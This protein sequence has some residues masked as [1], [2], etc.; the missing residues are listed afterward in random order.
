MPQ[1]ANAAPGDI[2]FEDDFTLY[3]LSPQ[4]TLSAPGFGTGF[5]SILS[6]NSAFFS[7]A[8][9]GGPLTLTTNSSINTSGISGAE[10]SVWVRRAAFLAPEGNDDLV[11]EYLNDSG[12]WI[13][14]ETYAGGGAPGQ[15]FNDTFT[16]PADALHAG[17]QL[18]FD[19]VQA[20]LGDYWYIDDVIVTETGVAVVCDAYTDT[21]STT[22]YNNSDGVLDWSS[23]SWFE[24]NDDGSSTSGD[25]EING[26][27]LRLSGN[28]SAVNNTM[29]TRQ[30]NTG[31][32]TSAT[33]SFD[34]LMI[35]GVDTADSALLEISDDG[36]SSWTTL[37]TFVGYSNNSGGSREYDITSY[38]ASNMQ[39]RFAISPD[40][41]GQCCFDSGGE[42]WEI[43]NVSVAACITSSVDHYFISHSGSGV[44]CESVDVSII[45]HDSSHV[46]TDAGGNTIQVTATSA[47]L[48]WS[49]ANTGWT[50][51]SGTGG[52]TAPSTGVAEYTFGSGEAAVTLNFS[53]TSV[54]TI[55]FDV[56]DQGNPSLTDIDGD[57]T[58][59]ASLTF[60]DT[61]F[62]FYD[63]SD[64]DGNRDP[65]GLGGFEGIQSELVAGAASNQMI[66]R[67]VQ[68]NNETGACEARV[69]GLQTVG[70]GYECIDPVSCT[71][72]TDYALI[73]GAPAGR[74]DFGNSGNTNGV[75]I[76]FDADGEAPFTLNYLDA[77]QIRLHAQLALAADPATGDPAFTLIGTS[78]NTTAAPD[79]FVISHVE[80]SAGNAADGSAF[81]TSETPFEIEVQVL[82]ALGDTT[83][84][85]GNESSPERIRLSV[86]S[87]DMPAGGNPG[88]LSY[89]LAKSG[90]VFTSAAST[91]NEAGTFT[92]LTDLDTSDGDAVYMS[93]SL[94]IDSDSYANLGRFYPA[95]FDLQAGSSVDNGCESGGFT[96][97][98][99]QAF[100]HNPIDLNISIEARGSANGPLSNYTTGYTPLAGFTLN[101]EN[102]ND[103]IDL[104]T[105]TNLTG[106]A[107]S[108]G[109]YSFLADDNAGFRRVLSGVNETLDGPFASLQLG[110]LADGTDSIEFLTA[111]LTM[112]PSQSNDCVTDGDCTAAAIGSPLNMLFGRMYGANAHGPESAALSVPLLVEY[113][114]GAEFITNTTDSCTQIAAGSIQ[115]DSNSLSSD[116]NRTVTVG[117]GTS[118]GSFADYTLGSDFTFSSGDAGLEFSAP[119]VGNTGQ[120]NVD[121]DLTNYPWLTNDW[122]NN[123]DY[124]NDTA[125]PSI[126]I[127]F[128][129]YRGHDRIIYWEEV[130][131]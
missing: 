72:D 57:V 78:D 5:L 80:D 12:S 3:Y 92:M 10:L 56:E 22:N 124:A 53:N 41:G 96:Y 114:S 45:A 71:N 107:W 102:S 87:V 125:L 59:D 98:S 30:V 99:D 115:F 112:E 58:E 117:G 101:A 65:D 37:E 123:G 47:T 82:N 110:L 42:R 43:D 38:A 2:L 83:P 17:L 64:S 111:D 9:G 14:L 20:D 77:G 18:R 74:N 60:T 50:L 85:F 23:N 16:L 13:A 52:F 29:I 68:T 126:E 1:T 6:Y 130:L 51:D 121:I 113:W 118:N 131:D 86:Q 70:F 105:R 21:F 54:A 122:D 15:E 55:D 127:E 84:N 100:A 31:G 62:L 11:L 4:W 27:E 36:G 119:G 108:S 129:R 73:S 49:A 28:G 69:T 26:D 8:L 97:M 19:F 39:I 32:A 95:S 25:V 67:A 128:G 7:L 33:L 40:S 75:N 106:G 76:T 24:T 79:S 109:T 34:F 35:G 94:S 66:L 44:T 93:T 104:S 63:D 116:A 120:F 48:G 89:S 88:T 103:G 81:I 90:G 91:W 61:G 46:A